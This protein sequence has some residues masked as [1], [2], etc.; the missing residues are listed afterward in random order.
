MKQLLLILLSTACC[1][2]ALKAQTFSYAT[3]AGYNNGDF[4]ADVISDEEGNVFVTGKFSD[5]IRFGSLPA[6]IS[7]GSTDIF[8][9]KFSASGTAQWAKKF[10][11]TSAD[12]GT[13]VKVDHSGN[14]YLCGDF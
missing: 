8:L 9:V 2:T 10:G 4:G 6:L 14:I 7:S 3:S 1:H 11:G 5:S 12:R 13:G